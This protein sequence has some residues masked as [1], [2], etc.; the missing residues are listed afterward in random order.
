ME[1]V[2]VTSMHNNGHLLLTRAII[3]A[4]TAFQEHKIKAGEIAKFRD[5]CIQ[6]GLNM[7]CGACDKTTK[8]PVQ[9]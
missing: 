4:I 2:N 8:I 7:E 5:V 1:C 3:A 6:A 9:V